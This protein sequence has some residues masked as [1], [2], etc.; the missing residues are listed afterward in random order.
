[1]SAP[2]RDSL[3]VI[4]DHLQLHAERIYKE[5]GTQEPCDSS[6]PLNKAP[7]IYIMFHIG[8]RPFDQFLRNEWPM[9]WSKLVACAK[10]WSGIEGARAHV[11]RRADVRGAKTCKSTRQLIELYA[12][13]K[14]PT[15]GLL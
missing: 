9:P 6:V 15:E 5:L 7:L 11:M 10:A 14:A 3:R 1:M 2:G 13:F 12:M 8:R 4:Y